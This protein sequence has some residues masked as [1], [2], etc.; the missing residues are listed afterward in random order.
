MPFRRPET[1]SSSSQLKSKL[2]FSAREAVCDADGLPDGQN[3]GGIG[4]SD[5]AHRMAD[6]QGGLLA[7]ELPK[8]LGLDRE[9]EGIFESLR[10]RFRV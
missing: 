1:F 7:P 8:V 2:P 10:L 6:Y 9:T 3:P 4:R 5:F